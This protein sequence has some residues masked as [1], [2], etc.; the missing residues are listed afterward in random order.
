[1]LVGGGEVGGAAAQRLGAPLA[2][3]SV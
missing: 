1:V 2:V 3:Q